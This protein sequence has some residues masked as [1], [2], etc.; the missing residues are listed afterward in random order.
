MDINRLPTRP[1]MTVPVPFTVWFDDLDLPIFGEAPATFEV[2]LMIAPDLEIESV[3]LYLSDQYD[4]T[5]V[6]SLVMV[7][8]DEELDIAPADVESGLRKSLTDVM[9][10]DGT[11]AGL[12]QMSIIQAGLRPGRA[13]YARLTFSPVGADSWFLE[14]GLALH[15]T[16]FLYAVN[17]QEVDRLLG[18][19][20][21]DQGLNLDRQPQNYQILDQALG[22]I[23]D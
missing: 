18:A 3:R 12:L 21:P 22:Q 1:I 11:E 19:N 23:G 5:G 2:F 20:E 17:E 14:P 13:V 10:L 7:Q 9:P 8:P 16:F 6:V 15:G 4:G